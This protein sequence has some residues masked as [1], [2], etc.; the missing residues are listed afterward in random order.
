MEKNITLDGNIRQLVMRALENKKWDYRTAEGIAKESNVSLE[1]V[2]KILETDDKVRVSV[3][4]SNI[5]KQLYTLKSKKSKAGDLLT[6]F[7]AMNSDKL[8][9]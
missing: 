9:G 5:G 6:A 4:K 7:R 1:N 2:K 3:M 8:G